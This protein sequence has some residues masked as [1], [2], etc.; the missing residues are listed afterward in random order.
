MTPIA[1]SKILILNFL[2]CSSQVTDEADGSAISTMIMT[3]SWNWKD[4]IVH[5][6][7]LA[8]V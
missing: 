6:L 4:A 1:T 5:L 2:L 7:V 3:P 8:I